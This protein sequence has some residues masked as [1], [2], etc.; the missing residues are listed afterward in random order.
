MNESDG[1]LSGTVAAI[2]TD[3]PECFQGGTV[4]GSVSDAQVIIVFTDDDIGA[5]ISLSGTLRGSRLDGTWS[6]SGGPAISSSGSS[7]SGVTMGTTVAPVITPTGKNCSNL[8]G[9]FFAEK[10]RT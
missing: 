1:T 10:V 6:I 9:D 8:R 5:V 7:G 4:T 2:Q 3:F